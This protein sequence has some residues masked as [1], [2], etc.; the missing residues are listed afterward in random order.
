MSTKNMTIEERK[1]YLDQLMREHEESKTEIGD[2]VSYHADFENY[3]R[4]AKVEDSLKEGSDKEGGYLVPNE[5]HDKLIQ[6]FEDAYVIRKLATVFTA[7]HNIS[8]P[9]VS[10]HGEA[11]WISEGVP[12]PESDEEFNGIELGAHKNGCITIVTDEL[13]EDSA[14]SIE[15]YLVETAG[16]KLARLEEEAFLCGDG[17][18][19]PRGVFLDAEVVNEV[20]E[21]TMDDAIDLYYGL[22]QCYRKNA[23][24]VMSEDVY[25]KL[26]KVRTVAGI[27]HNLWEGGL[28]DE[29]PVTLLGR[30]VYIST[31]MPVKAPDNAAIAFGDFRYYWIGERGNMSVKRLNEKYA[32]TGMVGFRVTHR[33]D[34]KLVLPEAVKTI[35]YK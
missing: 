22:K 12:Y 29:K 34:G 33:V 30:P 28:Q 3:L 27:E 2:S 20:A 19:K 21:I 15:N 13:L 17:I 24:W 9:G 18:N 10:K 6:K 35:K 11:D 7:D 8:I 23:V 31:L 1:A 4:T 14:F 16:D 25:S 5:Y 32:D 26:V